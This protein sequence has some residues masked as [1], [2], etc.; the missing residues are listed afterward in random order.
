MITDKETN[1][2]YFSDRI[3]TDKRY[4]SFWEGLEPLLV[5]N[6]ISF[7]FIENTKDIWCRDYMPIQISEKEFVQF[8]FDPDYLRNPKFTPSLTV[9]SEIKLIED[10]KPAISELIID[11]GNVVKS[12]DSVILTDRIF[13]ENPKFE[14]GEIISMLRTI[15]NVKHVFII[16]AISDDLS[17]HA[18]GMVRFLDDNTLLVSDYSYYPASWIQKMDKA[19]EKTGLELIT[20]PSVD[21]QEKNADGDY[22]A[23]GIYINFAQVS[24]KI[25]F[26]LF[27]LPGEKEMQALILT[28][29]LYP[30]CKVIP[31]NALEIAE[32]GGVLNCITWNIKRDSS[33]Q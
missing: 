15:L 18:D 8:K 22:T 20:F 12:N 32:Q 29:S 17:G 19:L 28:Q 9:Q 33:T 4:T 23:I 25:L 21:Y 1:F 24:D 2:V 5:E 30:N 26:P 10:L 11:G 13:I 6:N 16:P 7:G 14:E 31:I 27:A 3:K